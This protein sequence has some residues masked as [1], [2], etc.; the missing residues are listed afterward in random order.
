[1]RIRNKAALTLL[2][3]MPLSIVVVV[4]IMKQ[5]ESDRQL[6]LQ[7]ESKARALGDVV[8]GALST[9]VWTIE[10]MKQLACFLEGGPTHDA[11]SQAGDYK[12]PCDASSERFSYEVIPV[13][14][15]WFGDECSTPILRETR[16]NHS[17]RRV[18]V[19]MDGHVALISD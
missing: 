13:P 15:G 17:G 6:E 4:V 7:C 12:C 18:T 19:F 9:H 14:A 2:L 1:M 16:P 8:R 3:L 5:H 10:T 11:E